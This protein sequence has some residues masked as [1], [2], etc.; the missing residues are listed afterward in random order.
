MPRASLAVAL[1]PLLLL[2]CATAPAPASRPPSP[3]VSPEEQ[4]SNVEHPDT[5]S[6]K[7]GVIV[8]S[9]VSM[10][11]SEPPV[12]GVTETASPG[13]GPATGIGN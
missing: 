2:A 6:R 10:P 4:P 8:P 11:G 13:T 3:V 12:P 5:P 1:G 9:D 7:R